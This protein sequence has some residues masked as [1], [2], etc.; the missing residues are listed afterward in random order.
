M[1]YQYDNPGPSQTQDDNLPS[2]MDYQ[3][4]NPGPS[5][6]QEDNLPSEMDYQ[7]DKSGP[8]PDAGSSG[9][10]FRDL[11]YD[12]RH[13]IW[14][15]AMPP[16]TIQLMCDGGN[17]QPL[18]GDAR[19]IS[20]VNREARAIALATHPLWLRDSLLSWVRMDP[21]HDTLL[22][23]F[24]RLPPF[25]H[26]RSPLRK[27]V[28]TFKWPHLYNFHWERFRMR[29]KIGWFQLYNHPY[30]HEYTMLCEKAYPILWIPGCQMHDPQPIR[31]TGVKWPTNGPGDMNRYAN[32]LAIIRRDQFAAEFA[33][34]HG[35]SPSHMLDWFIY[36]IGLMGYSK[37]ATSVGGHWAGFRFFVDTKRVEFTP[38]AYHDVKDHLEMGVDSQGVLPEVAV[39]VWVIRPGQ[40]S[41]AP[42]ESYHGW[43][44]VKEYS[45]GEGRRTQ[46]IRALWQLTRVT[47]NYN[48]Q[49]ARTLKRRGD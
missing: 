23:S 12:I 7:H 47:F 10:R 13:Q 3:Y 27:V 35:H 49:F 17:K 20:H 39:R 1:D 28:S 9:F 19:D 29:S 16:T 32:R 31:D 45:A 36:R 6:I 30:L 26:R 11:P 15:E 44:R 48:Q 42:D 8:S 21:V 2:E 24:L 33:R 38:L 4:D 43:E 14:L 46:K 22:T 41:T 34:E 18:R 25:P 37:N 40:K 5:P